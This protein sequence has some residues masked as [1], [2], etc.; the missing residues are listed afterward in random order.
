MPSTAI[1][2]RRVL[3]LLAGGLTTPLWSGAA[4]AAQRKHLYLSAGA[5][6]SESYRAAGFSASGARILDEELP[7]R[8]HAFAVRPDGRQAVHFARR[9][10]SFAIA[11]DIDKGQAAWEFTA[12]EGRH[13]QGHGVFEPAGRLLYATENDFE[14]GRGVI[15]IYDAQDGFA[16]LGELSSHGIG[17]HDV[18]LLSDG[19]T[20]VVAN[21]G[22]QTHPDY[23]RVKLNLSTMEPSLCYI[24]RQ[25]GDLVRC[26]RLDRELRQLS[27]RHLAVGM[28]NRVFAAMQY[29][30]PK[31]DSVS[32]VALH[33]DRG[34]LG[35]LEAPARVLRAMRHYCGDICFDRG[36]RF[37]AVSSPRGNL[38]TVWDGDA[39][40]FLLS[41]PFDDCCGV[42]PG[43]RCGEF[44]VSSGSSGVVLL[45]ARS[46][47]VSLFRTGF[48]QARR[49]DNHLAV[50]DLP[51][52]DA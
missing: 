34:P 27:I 43:A 21:G 6:A 5:D 23:P 28:G 2:R 51:G 47:S 41:V 3:R 30:G 13:F 20:L 7:A 32:L 46:R 31:A 10:G 50:V 16:R 26:S 12:P 40:D 52:R 15:G 44:L 1:D 48:P 14:A 11:F 42:A 9:P 29:E 39:G 4:G 8:G 45:D 37:V 25:D 17:P 49:W 36:G 35:G 18:A 19:R 22:I 24:D 38:V 33:R